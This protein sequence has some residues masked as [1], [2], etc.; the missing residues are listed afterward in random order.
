MKHRFVKSFFLSVLAI[1]LVPLLAPAK[2][3]GKRP[4]YKKKS[5]SIVGTSKSGAIAR[6][7]SITVEIADSP[8]KWEYGLM[9]EKNLPETTGML[10]VFPSEEPRQFWMKNTFVDL[11]IGFF[12]SKLSLVSIQEMQKAKSEMENNLPTYPS[13]R[14]AQYALEVTKGWFTKNKIQVGDKLVLP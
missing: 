12:D 13:L 9:F 5:I 8:E 3:F 10:F 6:K 11:A 7:T 1:F 14:P 2:E 4:I